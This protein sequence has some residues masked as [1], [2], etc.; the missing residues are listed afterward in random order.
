[1]SRNILQS[2]IDLIKKY[3]GCYLT[4]YLCPAGVYT[5]GYGHTPTSKG[6]VITQD[7]ADTLLVLDLIKFSAGVEKLVTSKITDEQFGALVSL[8]YN[9]G[10]GNLSKSTLIRKLNTNNFKEAADQFL[11]WDKIHG[12]VSTGLR[13]RRK[14]EQSLFLTGLGGLYE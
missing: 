3:E 8:A 6:I 12:S 10:L 1:M 7:Q 4:S 2:A 9:I 5:I 14:E 11:V 13:R